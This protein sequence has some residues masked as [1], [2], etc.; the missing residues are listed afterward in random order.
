MKVG[1][2][3]N[4]QLSKQVSIEL[5]IAEKNISNKIIYIGQKY[6]KHRI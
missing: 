4:K 5:N 6:E 2:K 3:M 1:C